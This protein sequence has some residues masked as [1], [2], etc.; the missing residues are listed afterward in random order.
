M[1]NKRAG[2]EEC[3]EQ[4]TVRERKRLTDK[5][6]E[7]LQSNSFDFSFKLP[8][9]RLIFKKTKKVQKNM[10]VVRFSSISGEK[11]AIKYREIK[12]KLIITSERML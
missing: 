8:T 12:N 5:L 6:F 10:N 2:D 4:A 7:F 11:L 1:E 3:N 9:K